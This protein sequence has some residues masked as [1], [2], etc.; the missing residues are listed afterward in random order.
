M[1]RLR[2]ALQKAESCMLNVKIDLET[3]TEKA[4]TIATLAGG[5]KMIRA[6]LS[7][8]DWLPIP[9]TVDATKP[10]FH[11]APCLIARHDRSFGW[12]VGWGEWVSIHGIDGW[13]SRG[14]Y[15]V[16]GNLGLAAPTR[17]QPLPEP[18]QVK[19]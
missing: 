12:V 14:F 6:A 2:E 10:P 9:E 1:T 19:P 4:T 16:P 17:W 3:G 8:P 7:E 18:P 15:E 5:L 11:G 13:I